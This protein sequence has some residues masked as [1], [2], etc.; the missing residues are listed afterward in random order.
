M[1]E[2]FIMKKVIEAVFSG[3][4][5]N[6]FEGIMPKYSA[7]STEEEYEEVWESFSKDLPEEKRIEYSNLKIDSEYEIV[8]REFNNAFRLGFML[9]AEAFLGE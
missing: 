4:L 2:S 8:K 9:C 7:A 6:L 5:N 3:Y 1:K